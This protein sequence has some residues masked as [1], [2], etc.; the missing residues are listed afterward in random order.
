M[1][2]GKI[3]IS[4]CELGGEGGVLLNRF[5]L[6]VSLAKQRRAVKQSATNS[7]G[8]KF[9]NNRHMV[10]ND[11]PFCCVNAAI[12]YS[13]MFMGNKLE[14]NTLYSA[15]V[16]SLRT[17]VCEVRTILSHTQILKN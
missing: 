16:F 13:I 15:N 9:I 14:T 12:I 7:D 11:S 17:V 6:L 1:S 5:L 10:D 3:F 4:L 2:Y 8:R